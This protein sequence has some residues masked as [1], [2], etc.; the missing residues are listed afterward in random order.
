[1]NRV[2]EALNELLE[3]FESSQTKYEANERAAPVLKQL[4]ADPGFLR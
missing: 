3:V 4:A 2:D 1:M